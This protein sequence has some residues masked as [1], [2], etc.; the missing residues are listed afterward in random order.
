M[1][2]K[3]I[4]FAIDAHNKVNH[5][6]DNY[7]YSLHLSMVAMYA[8]KFIDC[9]PDQIQEDVLSACWLHDTI[10]DCRLT[11]NDILKISNSNVA[12]LV[13]AVTNEKGKNRSQRANEN[14]YEG[15]RNTPFAKFV[16]LCDRLANIKYS[17]DTDS[18]MYHKYAQE[19]EHFLKSLFP[20]GNYGEYK[21]LVLESK[22]LLRYTSFDLK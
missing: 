18:S 22:K 10:E 17:D 11:Y 8:T 15:I 16:K 2:T 19:H 3:I 13:Y 1:N 14:Y 6:Y 9:V 12:N 5:H 21:P 4:A 7:P 20:D